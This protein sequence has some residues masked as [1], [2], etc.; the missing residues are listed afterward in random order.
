MKKS[1]LMAT[2]MALVL[3]TGG[4]FAAEKQVNVNVEPGTIVNV[5]VQ[6]SW[7][8]VM[9]WDKPEDAFVQAKGTGLP[10]SYTGAK[11]RLMAR[12]AAIVDGYRM[13][14]ETIKGVNVEGD[15]TVGDQETQS[16]VVRAKVSAVIKGARILDEQEMPDGSYVVTMGIK[17][18]GGGS[19]AAAVM[20]E[21]MKET[22]MAEPPAV[23]TPKTTVMTKQEFKEVR[24][25]MK[26]A[27]YTGIVVDATGLGLECTMAPQILD[28]NGRGVYGK[29]NIDMDFATAHGLAEY[30]KN[31]QAATAGGTRAGNNPLVVKAR[32][33]RGG[34]NSVNPVNVV[35]SPEDADKILLAA[36]NN[37]DLF[38]NGQVV[39]VR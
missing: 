18:F 26:T 39:L 2:V 8:S 35:V 22:A 36:Q 10:G 34:T 6:K 13:L 4:V 5:S 7:D 15:T 12:R 28:S 27:G 23:V 14:A 29:V 17:L 31:V 9:R 19:V 37:P 33:V 1:V 20:P 16:D 30:S 21:V 25:E 38:K 32:G 24:Q 3:S 11:G